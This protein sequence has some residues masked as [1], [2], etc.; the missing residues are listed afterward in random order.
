M[1][2]ITSICN[3]AL[4]HCGTRSKITS[5]DE[6]SSEASACLTHLA[7]VRDATLRLFD[8]NFARMT[9]ELAQLPHP[10]ARWAFKYA[11]PSDCLRLRR[12]NDR[13]LGKPATFCELA[14]DRD[15]SGVPIAV[16]LTDLSPATAIYTARIENA[17][18]WDAG[19]VDAV[20][21]GL[22]ARIC[23]ELTG[24]DERARTLT[25]MWQGALLQAAAGS[26]NENA[27]SAL[28]ALPELLRV[29]T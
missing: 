3:A 5:L 14:A 22:A 29:R 26:A 18:R 24:R 4:S 16:V 8:W 15:D 10:T 12:L 11:L 28:P 7:L 27:L 19:F 17:A 23:F 13:P 6:G 2:D 20:T 21:W 1:T 9:G 25:Q